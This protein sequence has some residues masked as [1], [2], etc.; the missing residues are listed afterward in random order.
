MEKSLWKEIIETVRP[1]KKRDKCF[2][3]IIKDISYKKNSNIDVSFF[4]VEDIKKN[5]KK[6]L[7]D[8]KDI[9]IGDLSR[10][11]KS[12]YKNINRGNLKVDAKLDLH[13]YNLDLAFQKFISFICKNYE[14]E[15]RKL[16]IVTGKGNPL[17][18]TGV[19]RREL[20]LWLNYSD[21]KNKILYANFASLKDG[22]DGAFYILLRKK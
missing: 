8:E 22:G 19:I 2:G 7:I 4:S 3:E 20:P 9:F 21:I 6:N 1:L 15:N 16:L 17:K 5:H 11:D 12:L 14:S 18:N 13:G 10:I